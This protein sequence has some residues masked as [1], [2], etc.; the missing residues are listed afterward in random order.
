MFISIVRESDEK[1][2]VFQQLSSLTSSWGPSTLTT[3]NFLCNFRRSCS[4]S[5]PGEGWWHHESSHLRPLL[6]VFV[7]LS[8]FN[9]LTSFI[10]LDPSASIRW[11]PRVRKGT[12]LEI[13]KSS[14]KRNSKWTR[15]VPLWILLKKLLATRGTKS[16]QSAI[17]ETMD[18]MRY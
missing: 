15:G 13:A 6:A 3:E 9:I 4:N 12:W 5:P 2:I 7:K 8:H 14:L 18:P 17:V 1:T 11:E 16:K 10:V